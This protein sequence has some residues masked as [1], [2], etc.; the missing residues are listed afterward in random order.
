MFHE[1]I[2]NVTV[3]RYYITGEIMK[4]R[5]FDLQQTQTYKYYFVCI[6]CFNGDNNHGMRQSFV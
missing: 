2:I 4:K 1:F 6:A 3:K 5:Q